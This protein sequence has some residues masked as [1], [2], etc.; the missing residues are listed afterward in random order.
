[1]N[2]NLVSSLTILYVHKEL[3]DSNTELKNLRQ[4]NKN[5]FVAN[6]VSEAKKLYIKNQP[7]VVISDIYL[8]DKK[9]FSL[10]KF[11]K[12]I[13]PYQPVIIST[14]SS[15]KKHM[16][17]AFDLNVNSYLL[18]P[19]SK[20]ALFEKIITLGKEFILREK[21]IETRKMLQNILNNQSGLVMLTDFES[22]SYCS[23]SFLE[24]FHLN[25]IS[26]LFFRYDSITGLFIKHENYLHGNNK[27]EFLSAFK[28]AKAI[29]KI[30]L[31]VG[32]T[33]TPKAFHI[34][35]NPIKMSEKESYIVT[36]TNISI[37]QEKNIEISY[38][39]YTDTLT[40]VYNRNKFEEVFEYESTRNK[41]YNEPLTIAVMDIDHFKKFNDTYGHLVG[42]EVLKSM[43]ETIN[44][45]VRRSDLFARWGGE[46]FVLIMPKTDLQQAKT[47]CEKLRK[48]I[49]SNE[50]KI[51]GKIT[52]SFGVT[53]Y[54]QGDDMRSVFRRSDEAL[55]NA[56]ANGRN[57]VEVI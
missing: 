53:Q 33:L 41:R 1:M 48:L 43:A 17:K 18:N 34:D 37:M 39:A 42:D 50:H 45:N 10:I 13:N 16:L 14:F 55:Y 32:R 27:E 25:D 23:K 3:S 51:A 8:N 29:K 54:E 7:S 11:I 38:K 12:E 24:F 6:T 46:E 35:I 52:C 28:N 26:E 4:Y 5:I 19:S 30:V 31:M 44:E 21:N 22:I 47:L 15:K 36:L 49:E 40:G 2:D 20:N 57:R 9:A 56:K